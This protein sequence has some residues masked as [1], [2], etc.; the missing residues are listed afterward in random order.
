M[1][2]RVASVVNAGIAGRDL[3][4]LRLSLLEQRAFRREQL[5]RIRQ[6]PPPGSPAR[7]RSALVEVQDCL[8][9]GARIVLADVEAALARMETGHYGRCCHCREAVSLAR[10][11]I[12][13]Q[14]LYCAECHRLREQG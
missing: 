4:V 3:A 5:R 7:L 6:A 13:P 11:R 1:A 9:T 14:T 2:G 12:C 8:A 10:L